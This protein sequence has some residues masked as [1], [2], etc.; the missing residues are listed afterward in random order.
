M[1]MATNILRRY[2]QYY[3]QLPSNIYVWGITFSIGKQ[4]EN[5]FSS[6]LVLSKTYT[7]KMRLCTH[8]RREAKLC[9][10]QNSNVF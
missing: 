6:V 1:A 2:L 3:N 5:T 7:I 8:E 9:C 10:T 4:E